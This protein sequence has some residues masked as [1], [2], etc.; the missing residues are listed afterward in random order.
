MAQRIKTSLMTRVQSLQPTIL[1][2]HPLTSTCTVTY[3]Q[4]HTLNYLTPFAM[5]KH[6]DKSDLPEE[7]V[8]LAYNSRWEAI[9]VGQGRNLKQL[10]TPTVNTGLLCSARSP[11]LLNASSQGEWLP[12]HEKVLLPLSCSKGKTSQAGPHANPIPIVL[13]WDSSQVALGWEFLMETHRALQS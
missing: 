9:T 1:Q 13:H 8:A 4:L 6:H 2:S 7:R 11:C 12:H 3:T 10:A 5:V